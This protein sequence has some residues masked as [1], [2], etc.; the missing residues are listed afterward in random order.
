MPQNN[1]LVEILGDL[2]IQAIKE[3]ISQIKTGEAP[4]AIFEVARKLLADNKITADVQ[5]A[6][7][8]KRLSQVLPFVDPTMPQVQGG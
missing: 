3:I 1:E 4:P 7:Q 5:K 2:Q 8:L 6:P